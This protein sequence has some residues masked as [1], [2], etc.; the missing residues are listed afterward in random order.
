M[1]FSV[2]DFSVLNF[3]VQDIS[4][5]NF[6]VPDFSVLNFSVPD[7]SVPFSLQSQGQNELFQ[8]QNDNFL[9]VILIFDRMRLTMF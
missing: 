8:D 4:V 3:T 6:T 2:P 9:R 1:N 5:L 7:L